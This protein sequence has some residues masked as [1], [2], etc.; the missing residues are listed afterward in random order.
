MPARWLPAASS[1]RPRL[2][3]LGL[4]VALTCALSAVVVTSTSATAAAAPKP[5]HHAVAHAKTP[6]PNPTDKQI[7]AAA[8]AKSQAASDV[9]RL[10]GLIAGIN[11]GSPS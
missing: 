2:R 7:K 5:A 1:G 11:G 8:A 4:L 3:A 6:P 9:G 10:S